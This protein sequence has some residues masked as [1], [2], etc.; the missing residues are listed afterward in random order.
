MA[1]WRL[2]SIVSCDV[3]SFPVPSSS[4]MSSLA[5]SPG[6]SPPICRPLPPV[7]SS[8]PSEGPP[9]GDATSHC[10]PLQSGPRSRAGPRLITPEAR[11]GTSEGCTRVACLRGGDVNSSNNHNHVNDNAG[12]VRGVHERAVLPGMGIDQ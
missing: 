3:G 12:N 8:C 7:L 11:L 5:M 10:P 9:G 2:T 4:D 1:K 6:F